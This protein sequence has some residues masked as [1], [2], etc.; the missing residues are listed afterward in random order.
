MIHVFSI[1]YKYVLKYLE[2]HFGFLKNSGSQNI[3]YLKHHENT[4]HVWLTAAAGRESRREAPGVLSLWWT[5]AHR[6]E[7]DCG[8]MR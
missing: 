2:E 1:L 4:N 8:Q 3:L 6:S 5:H 7:P